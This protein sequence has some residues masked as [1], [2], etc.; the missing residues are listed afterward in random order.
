[1]IARRAAAQH[2]LTLLDD[3]SAELAEVRF[4][5]ETLWAN[6]ALAGAEAT[7]DQPTG[8]RIKTGQERRAQPITSRAEAILHRRTRAVIEAAM[9]QP[10]EGRP[11]VVVT[12]HAPHPLCL[13][14]LYRTGWNAGN[15]ASDFRT[16]LTLAGS[17]CGCTAIS[18][19]LSTWSGPAVRASSA[20][21]CQATG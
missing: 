7:P 11:L 12:H 3:S 15:A 5:G 8:E 17:R 2:G 1:M 6:G 10:A 16:L 18:T 20:T 14:A 21:Q 4:V 9:A 13:P 19:R